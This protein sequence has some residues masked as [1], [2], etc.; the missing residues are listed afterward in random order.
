MVKAHARGLDAYVCVRCS[1][2]TKW[3][4]GVVNWRGVLNCDYIFLARLPLV[5]SFDYEIWSHILIYLVGPKDYL[6][7]S[8]TF[9]RDVGIR[10]RNV[11]I[12][13]LRRHFNRWSD[14]NYPNWK[15]RP[16]GCCPL[17]VRNWN[18]W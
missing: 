15:W 1:Q 14:I 3:F 2:L 16:P 6:L 17:V 9:R 12:N 11:Q 18:Y 13:E 7:P 8:G 5:S 10:G 4:Y